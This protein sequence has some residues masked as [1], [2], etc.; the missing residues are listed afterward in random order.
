MNMNFMFIDIG[1]EANVAAKRLSTMGEGASGRI[2]ALRLDDES[3]RQRLE[4]MGLCA[5]RSVEVVKAGDPMIVRVLGTLIGL[6]SGLAAA[7]LVHPDRGL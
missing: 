2:V 1:R 6:A 7:A 4:A 3:D 5:G